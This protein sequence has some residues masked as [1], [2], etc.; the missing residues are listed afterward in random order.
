MVAVVALRQAEEA[1]H[2]VGG[3]L[4]WWHLI[5]AYCLQV[6][7]DVAVGITVIMAVRLRLVVVVTVDVVVMQGAI[8]VV[9]VSR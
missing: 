9:R 4:P 8:L 2:L 7:Q 3:L 6:V 1:Y 5:N